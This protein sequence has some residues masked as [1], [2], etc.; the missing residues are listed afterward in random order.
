MGPWDRKSCGHAQ[1]LV[2]LRD[3]YP[4]HPADGSRMLRANAKEAKGRASNAGHAWVLGGILAD[5][6]GNGRM[7]LGSAWAELIELPFS[8]SSAPSSP[9][10]RQRVRCPQSHTG[11]AMWSIGER[12][13]A[14]ATEQWQFANA[15]V[16]RVAALPT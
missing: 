1:A 10:I 12:D 8:T 4:L 16:F 5:A 14:H 11:R 2:P 3:I 9:N 6:A 7:I 15:E 13:C